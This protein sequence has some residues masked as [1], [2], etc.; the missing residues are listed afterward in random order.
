MGHLAWDRFAA[1]PGQK[2]VDYSAGRERAESK[3][4]DKL[5][6]H[7]VSQPVDSRKDTQVSQTPDEWW[8]AVCDR[9]EDEQVLAQDRGNHS[10]S[11]SG[12]AGSGV[13]AS[14]APRNMGAMQRRSREAPH[15]GY[16]AMQS[17]IQSTSTRGGYPVSSASPTQGPRLQTP[18]KRGACTPSSAVGVAVSPSQ[19]SRAGSTP[20]RLSTSRFDSM[21][22]APPFG[23]ESG[24]ESRFAVEYA[25][26]TLPCHIDHRTSSNQLTWDIPVEEV[27]ERRAALLPLC[28]DG[29]RETRHPHA[30]V[31]RLAFRDLASLDNAEPLEDEAMRRVMAGLRLALLTE[32]GGAP[33]ASRSPQQG[34]SSATIF[35]SALAAVRQIAVAERARIVPH[36][37][38]ILPPIGKKMFSKLHRESVQDTLRTIEHYGGQ[39]AASVMRHRGVQPGVS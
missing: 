11:V 6:A 9:Y 20:A 4:N 22:V 31:A 3:E 18:S 26:R 35:E 30:T 1:P 21:R 37:H 7:N 28:A 38:L 15:K 33:A 5:S 29:L 27:L 39:E 25:R 23:K 13:R 34:G 10:R 32:G 19:S 14:S 36:L 8:E 17:P 24:R 2:S 12:R 16:P